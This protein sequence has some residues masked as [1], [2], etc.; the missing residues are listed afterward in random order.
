MWSL[1]ETISTTA[2]GKNKAAWPACLGLSLNCQLSGVWAYAWMLDLKHTQSHV[3][4]AWFQGSGATKS[5]GGE[6]CGEGVRFWKTC[7]WRGYRN[8]TS[9]Y[10]GANLHQ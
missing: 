2:L 9:I 1:N 10:V 8:L 3:W 5:W 4:K 6:A 7:P